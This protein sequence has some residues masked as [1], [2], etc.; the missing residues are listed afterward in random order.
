MK[1]NLPPPIF[2]FVLFLTI[3]C[4]PY[5]TSEFVLR[6]TTSHFIEIKAYNRIET[7]VDEKPVFKEGQLYAETIKIAPNSKYSSF[8]AW[9][10]YDS[11]GVFNQRMVDS[12]SI[13]F[14][15][16]RIIEQYWNDPYK[17]FMEVEKNLMDI[18][19]SFEME[20]I[21]KDETRYTYFFTEQ[22]FERARVLD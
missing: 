21:S 5:G 12:I 22:D 13:V 4:Q 11:R 8:K 14:D 17:N 10:N 15:G 19:Q 18:H 9:G 2:I 16:E 20:K 1:T 3:S 7:F 6:N